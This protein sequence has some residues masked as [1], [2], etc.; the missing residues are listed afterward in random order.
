MRT[1]AFCTISLTEGKARLG[2]DAGAVREIPFTDLGGLKQLLT[3]DTAFVQGDL[4][5]FRRAADNVRLAQLGGLLCASAAREWSPEGTAL[6]GLNGNGCAHNNRLYWNDFV[7]NGRDTGRASLF[8]PTLPSIP[9]CE[10]AITLGIRG[11]VRYIKT[12]TEGQTAELLEEMFASDALLRQTMTVEIAD[13]GVSVRLLSRE[14][15]A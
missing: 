9:V 15:A 8:V 10:A 14:P 5:D 7:V 13:D 11:P 12:D 1:T 4:T 2:S 6:I 3:D